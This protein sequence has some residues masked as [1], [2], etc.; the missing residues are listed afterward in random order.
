MSPGHNVESQHDTDPLRRWAPM[1]LN[2]LLMVGL[3]TSCAPSPPEQ[4]SHQ[5]TLQST[6]DASRESFDNALLAAAD[7]LYDASTRAQ[8]DAL[9]ASPPGQAAAAVQRT[10]KRA[11]DA[12]LQTRVPAVRFH[13]TQLVALSFHAARIT[14]HYPLPDATIDDAT[15]QRARQR[16]RA[17]APGELV[18]WVQKSGKMLRLQVYDDE[19]HMRPEAY[20]DFSKALYAPGQFERW[21]ENPWIAQDPRLLAML[22]YTAQ[23]FGK[24]LEIISAFRV[25]KGKS[26][27]NHHK[28]RAIDFRVRGVKRRR[29]LNYLDRSFTRVGVGWYPNSTF[30]HLDT[31]RRSYYW[32]DYSR[33]GGR[34]RSRQR[35]VDKPARPRSDPTRDTV[36]MPLNKMYR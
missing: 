33:P 28:G 10:A 26:S 22:T 23:H 17:L 7:T 29:L 5:A 9:H 14:G 6:D 21:G 35:K 8:E 30:I 18:I 19:G 13:A 2:G 31:R 4:H 15:R 34:Q 32:T 12:V 16:K 24:P 20:I 1:L 3:L 36:H 27:S 25:P 11:V